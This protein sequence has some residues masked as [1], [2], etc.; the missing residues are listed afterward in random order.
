MSKFSKLL[1]CGITPLVTAGSVA[2]SAAG[3]AAGDAAESVAGSAGGEC[4]RGEQAGSVAGSA[5]GSVAGCAGGER[6]RGARLVSR[7]VIVIVITGGYP[8]TRMSPPL[9]KQGNLGEGAWSLDHRNSCE[10]RIGYANR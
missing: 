5:A 9:R 4:R 3:V 7:R 1:D 8:S 6:R 10:F 2:G